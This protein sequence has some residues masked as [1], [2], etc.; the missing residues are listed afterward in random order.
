MNRRIG[1]IGIILESRD[2]VDQVNHLISESSSIILARVGLPQRERGVSVITL[3]VEATTDEVGLLTGR[4][5]AV[6]GVSVKSGLAKK[7]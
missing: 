3:V 4:L 2:C 7:F 5:G 6:P 1:F